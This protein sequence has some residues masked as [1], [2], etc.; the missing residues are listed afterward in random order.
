MLA[1]TDKVTRTEKMETNCINCGAPLESLICSHCGT[2]HIDQAA[3]EQKNKLF[4]KGNYKE[5]ACKICN[6]K[7]LQEK[8]FKDDSSFWN[9]K[10]FTVWTCNECDNR[11]EIEISVT[12]YI[13]GISDQALDDQKRMN[14]TLAES[15]DTVREQI[16]EIENTI[17]KMFD[18][19]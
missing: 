4:E 17:N 14:Q 13:K 6:E 19:K 15:K 2:K 1:L 3:E 18:K 5:R 7:T 11:E 12:E 10:H 9:T 16:S 8:N